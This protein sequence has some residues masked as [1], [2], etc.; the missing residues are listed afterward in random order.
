MIEKLLA[1]ITVLWFYHSA[2]YVGEKA[3]QWAVIGLIGFFLSAL[4]MHFVIAEPILESMT[5]PSKM[6]RFLFANLP[7][8]TGF[9]VAFLI[10]RKY[11]L[12]AADDAG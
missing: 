11:L 7:G 6:I 8:I 1:I 4:I 5:N 9:F 2:K 10:R 12:K 3:I